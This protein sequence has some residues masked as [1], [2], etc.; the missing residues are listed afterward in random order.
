MVKMLTRENELRLSED[1][2]Q[3]MEKA[4][5]SGHSEWMD[6][7]TEV[8]RQ[9]LCEFGVSKQNLHAGLMALRSA[10]LRHPEI[11]LYVKYN[12]ARQ[13][14]LRVGC[15]APDVK[16]VPVRESDG[17]DLMSSAKIESSSLL[18]YERQGRPLV[19]VA[20]SYS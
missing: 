4:E 18:Q 3:K 15:P 13:G 7:A 11:A 12:R 16:V 14:E 8:Q 1:V 17:S 9:V 19:V 5:S 2:Q 10:A 20:G 6:V